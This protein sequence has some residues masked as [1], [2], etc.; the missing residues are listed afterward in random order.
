MRTP[1]LHASETGIL[2]LK[3]EEPRSVFR[4]LE[5]VTILSSEAGRLVVTDGAGNTVLSCDVVA[6]GEAPYT[7]GGALGMQNAVLQN[8]TGDLLDRLRFRVDAQTTLKDSDDEFGKLFRLLEFGLFNDFAPARVKRYNGKLYH[9][10]SAW[11]QDH[12][13]L[14]LAKKYFYPEL[15]SGVDLYMHGQ[16][17]D[18]MVPDTYK[19]A[20]G[21][22]GP[23]SRRFD[24]GNFVY[25]PEDPTSS[26][27]FVKVPVENMTEFSYIETVFMTWQATGDD[28]W[29]MEKLDSCIKAVEYSTS[30]PYRWSEKCQLLKRGYT[31]DIWDFQSHEDTAITGDTMKVELAKTRFNIMYGDNVR[32]AYSCTVLADMLEF[33]G[34]Q[35]AAKRIRETGRGLKERIDALSW[36]GEFYRHQVPEDPDVVRDFGDTDVDAQVTL[37][38][39][40]ALNRGV[41]HEQASGIIKTYQRIREAM[42]ETSPGEWYMCYPPFEKGWKNPK[43]NYMNGGVSPI[44]AGELAKGCFEHGFE[45]YGVD[46]LRRIYDLAHRSNDCLY[47]GYKGAIEPAPDRTFET[48]DLR[49]WANA[50]TAGEGNGTVPVW[51]K[52][53]G[54][55]LPGFPSGR[56]EFH[57]VPFDL[58]KPEDNGRRAALGLSLD[59]GYTTCVRI[60]VNRKAGSLYFLHVQTGGPIAGTVTF[61]YADGTAV[62]RYVS[63]IGQ[64]KAGAALGG[65]WDPKEEKVNGPRKTLKLAWVGRNRRSPRI[66]VWEYGMDNPNPEKEIAAIELDAARESNLWLILGLTLSDAPAY[67]TPDDISTL[68]DHWGAAECMYGLVDGLAGVMDLDRGMRKVRL[69]PRWAAAGK[70]SASL[71]AKYEAC[72]AY[73]SYEYASDPKRVSLR[74]TGTPEQIELNILLPEEFEPGTVA[75]D[76]N[77]VE[78]SV[79]SI[80]GSRYLRCSAERGFRVQELRINRRAI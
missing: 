47:G 4:P 25:V 6:A 18:G 53:E 69:S 24:Y 23:W 39:A 71:T 12:M 45:A 16:R 55:D 50:D 76:G 57:D 3:S 80:E 40:W 70:A 61:V 64:G 54:N 22:D 65:F 79:D 42:P 34:R 5:T 11:F 32:M 38:N 74:F 60:D 67:F 35:E 36:N 43:W 28:A 9:Y 41:T 21:K 62:S 72:D 20:Y 78:F 68:P 49:E 14:L 46:I 15:K 31:I 48:I 63:N 56:T 19:H 8:E 7:V 73:I 27:N 1:D 58:V 66:G 51:A 37:S 2:E 77:A 29:M 30:D 13:Y 52:D 26:C 59:P 33:A 10:F 44:A 75:L 17:D